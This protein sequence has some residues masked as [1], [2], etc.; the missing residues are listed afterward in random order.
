MADLAMVEDDLA[1]RRLIRPCPEA[2]VSGDTYHFVQPEPEHNTPIV[3]AF[4]DWL[5]EEA[6][7]STIQ[8]RTVLFASPVQA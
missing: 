4:R 3:L 2:M 7:A 1:L 8:S 6:Q 5:L